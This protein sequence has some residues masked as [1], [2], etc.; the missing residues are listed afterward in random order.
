MTE[1]TPGLGGVLETVLYYEPAERPRVERFY[2]EVLGLR[3]VAQW[4]DGIAYRVGS[5]VLL[6]FDTQKLGERTEPHSRHGA[7]GAGHVCL[8][9]EPGGYEDWKRHLGDHEVRIDHEASWPG[10]ARSVYFRDPADNLLEIADR[11][12]WPQ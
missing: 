11:D 2:S 6:L 10:G 9:A 1:A 7:T 12:L 8:T 3:P 4:G 5:G